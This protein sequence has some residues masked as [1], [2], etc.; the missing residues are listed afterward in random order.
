MRLDSTHMSASVKPIRKFGTTTRLD[1]LRVQLVVTEL[2][3]RIGAR[4]NQ[5]RL[6][7]GIASQRRLAELINEHVQQTTGTAGGADG[8]RVSDWERG[9]NKPSDRYL[10]ALAHVLERD[11]AWF[12]GSETTDQTPDLLEVTARADQLDEVSRTFDER[13]T[14]IEERQKELVRKVSEI[15]T[16]VRQLAR[17]DVPAPPDDLGRVVKDDPPTPPT[18]Q[19]ERR[20]GERRSQSNTA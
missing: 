18:G 1:A 8:Q 5:A 3:A 19:P 16:M 17:A 2:N 10:H 11:V 15:L 13:V 12:Y 20:Q 7:K 4:I 9:V 6:E 14:E